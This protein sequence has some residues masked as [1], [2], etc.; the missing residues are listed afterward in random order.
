M[1]D[2]FEQENPGCFD[3]PGH[4]FADLYMKSGLF[5]AEIVKR[6]FNS[7]GMRKAFPDDDARLAH[8]FANQVFG[9][10][11]TEIIYRIATN[12]VLGFEGEHGTWLDSNFVM[13][14]TAELAKEGKLAE[15]VQKEFGD[16]LKDGYGD[17][18]S[19]MSRKHPD[20]PRVPV[21]AAHA[22]I[23]GRDYDDLLEEYESWTPE[24]QA[25]TDEV[26]NRDNMGYGLEAWQEYQAAEAEQEAARQ[27]H[28]GEDSANEPKASPM[29][30][31]TVSEKTKKHEVRGDWILEA[32][33]S[34]GFEYVDKR[35]SG[36][37]LWVIGDESI[38]DAMRD[39]GKRGAKFKFK[40][41]GG[42]KTKGKPAWFISASDSER[43]LG[44]D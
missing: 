1:V 5:I 20:E 22:V 13:A 39:L 41:K 12:F 44:L 19:R 34:E 28:S 7:E 26:Y 32:I 23:T 31:E 37:N 6:L 15:F 14:D 38:G 8:I 29:K 4:T 9:V 24:Q 27:E 21:V 25:M 3:D 10:A 43:A 40:A 18:P 11:P 30:Q 36:G 16:K 35:G 2:L 42:K 17:G 33:K